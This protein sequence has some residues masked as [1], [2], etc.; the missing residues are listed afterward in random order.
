MNNEREFSADELDNVLG[1][2]PHEYATEKALE[3]PGVFRS[4][5]NGELSADELD[6][7][8]GGVPYDYAA[9]KALDGLKLDDL[10]NARDQLTQGGSTP[11]RGR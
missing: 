11:R 2:V 3:N 10:K 8:L 6:N 7:A 1:G 5:S 9:E 4:D